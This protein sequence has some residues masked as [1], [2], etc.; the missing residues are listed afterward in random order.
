MADFA[1][2]LVVYN[3][4]AFQNRVKVAQAVAAYAVLGETVPG[5]VVMNNKR[6]ALAQQ[7]LAEPDRMAQ[8]FALLLAAHDVPIHETDEA[9]LNMIQ[10]GFDRVAGVTPEDRGPAV[11]PTPAPSVTSTP[12]DPSSSKLPTSAGGTR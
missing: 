1:Q 4:P 6:W 7:I 9:L 5:R 3:T 10:Q 8:Q 12:T 2:R 11:P